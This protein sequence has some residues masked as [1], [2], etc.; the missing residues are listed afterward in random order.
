MGAIPATNLRAV[1]TMAASRGV[2]ETVQHLHRDKQWVNEKHLEVCRIAAPTFQEQKRAEWMLGAFRT[3]GCEAKLDAAGNV[4]AFLQP[5][6]TAPYVALTAHMDTVLWPQKPEDIRAEPNGTYFG[7]GVSD[8][9]AG[10][11]GLLAIARAMKAAPAWTGMS[12]SPVFI[13][14]VGEEGEGN[15]SGMRHLCTESALA[16]SVRAWIVLDGPSTEH[17]T[18]Q[19]LA[20]RRFEITLQGPGGHSWVDFGTVNPVHALARTITV[21]AENVAQAGG[22]AQMSFNFGLIEGG[23]SVNAIPASARAKVDMRA[24]DE[25]VLERM[26]VILDASVTRACAWEG[27]QSTTGKLNSK[28]REV[29]ARPGGKLAAEASLLK[30]AVL[31]DAYLGIRSVMDCASTDA[32]IPLSLGMPALAIG[33]GGTGGGAHTPGE[34]FRPAGRTVG[35]ERALLVLAMTMSE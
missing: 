17:L 3:M 16:A 24:I 34:W 12:A 25:T 28:L 14:N 6:A 33:A 22:G 5:G 10:L 7:P 4:V 15:L 20:S 18:C 35:L 31:V 11:A 32:N 13:A 9:G 23:V 21:F 2:K 27:E 8:N 29:G 19:A 26:R 1:E 30:N